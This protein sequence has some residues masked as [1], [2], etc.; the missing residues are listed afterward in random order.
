MRK[1]VEIKPNIFNNINSNFIFIYVY[2]IQNQYMNCMFLT[3][4]DIVT[5]SRFADPALQK[6]PFLNRCFTP[7]E[8]TYCLSKT[9]PPPHFAVRFAA[10]EAV[11][12]ALSGLNLYLERN[13]IE[14]TNNKI[15]RPYITFRC[16]NPCI[17]QLKSDISLSHSETAA[18]AFVILWTT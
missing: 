15:G 1:N 6:Q 13:M 16:D 11:I 3:G 8:Q 17:L 7:A 2:P 12:K 14:I 10:K 4:V 5:I 18:I 9:D